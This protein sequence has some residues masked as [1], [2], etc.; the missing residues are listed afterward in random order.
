MRISDYEKN[1]IVKSVKNVDE[2][3]KIWLFGSRTDDTQKGGDIDIA[4]FSDKINLIQ[5]YLIKYGIEKEIGL[6]KIDIVV[7]KSFEKP[8]FS[9]AVSQGV[10]LDEQ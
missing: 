5:K 9:Y 4:I 3:A 7:S 1:A 10:R 2:T 8:F 6:Q